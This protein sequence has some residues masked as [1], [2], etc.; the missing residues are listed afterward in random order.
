LTLREGQKKHKENCDKCLCKALE[1]KEWEV[2]EAEDPVKAKKAAAA[3][4]SVIR[5]H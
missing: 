2:K 1:K 3:I 4:E 5:K